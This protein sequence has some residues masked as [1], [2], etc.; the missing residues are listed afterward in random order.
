MVLGRAEPSHDHTCDE[1]CDR[2]HHEHKKIKHE[3][4]ELDPTML[5]HWSFGSFISTRGDDLYRD[6]CWEASEKVGERERTKPGASACAC[7]VT[8]FSIHF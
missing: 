7:N 2:D 8:Y 3:E 5:N 1:N 6:V 4:G